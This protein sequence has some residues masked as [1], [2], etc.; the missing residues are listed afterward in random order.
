MTRLFSL[1]KVMES[2]RLAER[3]DQQDHPINRILKRRFENSVSASKN[4][5]QEMAQVAKILSKAISTIGQIK[6]EELEL[7]DLSA[8]MGEDLV[9]AETINQF[10]TRYSELVEDMVRT[11]L[12]NYYSHE[13]AFDVLSE[14]QKQSLPVIAALM[15]KPFE[16]LEK[17]KNSYE[18]GV[19][20]I[21]NELKRVFEFITNRSEEDAQVNSAEPISIYD[22]K[23]L[24]KR[25][26]DGISRFFE[27]KAV[28][29]ISYDHELESIGLKNPA[30]EPIRVNDALKRVMNEAGLSVAT[31]FAKEDLG[32]IPFIQM[33]S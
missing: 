10:K 3:K 31:H 33:I 27:D 20:V 14:D 1:A 2:Q 8:K 21:K 28:Q 26:S 25:Y 15:R 12:D 13:Q 11:Y 17:T 24:F 7:K 23:K 18:A 29:L 19:P 9:R 4:E 6:E 16:V 32:I 5:K 22:Q 30:F